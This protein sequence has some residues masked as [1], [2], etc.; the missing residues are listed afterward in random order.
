MTTDQYGFL[1]TPQ[2][3]FIGF[4]NSTNRALDPVQNWLEFWS[5]QMAAHGV[6][7]TGLDWKD[8]E[9]RGMTLI[10]ED[11]GWPVPELISTHDIRKAIYKFSCSDVGFSEEGQ[12]R[13][14]F[15]RVFGEGVWITNKFVDS[16]NSI[17]H[18]NFNSCAIEE[19]SMVVPNAACFRKIHLA[20]DASTGNTYFGFKSDNEELIQWDYTIPVFADWSA[21]T[22]RAIMRFKNQNAITA[23]PSMGGNPLSNNGTWILSKAAD[24][25]INFSIHDGT[26]LKTIESDAA[27]NNEILEIFGIVDGTTIKMY[28]DG[29]LQ[30][31]TDTLSAVADYYTEDSFFIG[32]PI[33]AG[34]NNF[35]GTMFE[36]AVD[37][38]VITP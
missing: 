38:E 11:Q 24:N 32:D 28:I 34:A 2:M 7:P 31:N 15:D 3:R 19:N 33:F 12:M 10:L 5:V 9:Q 23:G 17:F 37:A 26:S 25:K 21:L 18:C 6:D 4:W 36:C 22:V 27:H 14:L 8:I 30:A 20:K 1:F 29:V 16:D 13:E 35:K